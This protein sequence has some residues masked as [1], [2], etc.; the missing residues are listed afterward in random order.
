[1]ENKNVKKKN[2]TMSASAFVINLSDKKYDPD[3]VLAMLSRGNY[4]EFSMAVK[5]YKKDMYGVEAEK[6]Y[7][8]TIGYVQKYDA[9]AKTFEFTVNEKNH[10][11]L[12]KL[13]DDFIIIPKISF[14]KDGKPR[15]VLD[16]FLYPVEEEDE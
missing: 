14:M 3:E 2:F 4:E 16:L 15:K 8:L 1:M 12:T 6:D 10:N 9:E 5:M 13:A 11:L 7:G